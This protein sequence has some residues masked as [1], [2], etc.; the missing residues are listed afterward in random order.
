MKKRK[1][2]THTD[3]LRWIGQGC[4]QGR[5][6]GYRPFFHV[7]D[8]P[9]RGRSA[10]V[11]GLKTGRVHHYL[12]DLEYAC[13]LLAEYNP[14]VTDIREQF[15]LLPREET[16]A[17][18]NSLGIRH[19]IYP[20]TTTPIV[21][22]S[23][24]VLTLDQESTQKYAVI[25]VKSFSAIDPKTPR[26]KRTMEKLLVEKTYWDRRGIPWH[27]VSEKDIPKVRVRNLEKLRPSMAAEEQD[28][29]NCQ[30]TPFL[31]AFEQKWQPN[32]TLSGI[33][34]RISAQ[35]DVDREGC[36]SLFAKAVW[37][38]LLPVDL[39]AEVIH[40]DQPLVI[41]VNQGGMPC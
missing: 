15:A 41:T 38:R 3:V 20:G 10:M 8:V 27:L 23:D 5:G 12:S 2:V 28:H 22:T 7:R 36:F 34:N 24:L 39:D 21:M 17:I 30:L 1:G 14:S 18:A 9:S 29:L 4:G 6:L 16:Q 32:R 19:P 35:I 31:A 40:H 26:A 37:M 25:C 33:L 11:K 13:H